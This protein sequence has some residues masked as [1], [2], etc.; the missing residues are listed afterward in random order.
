MSKW[1]CLDCGVH[2]GKIREHFDLLD[3]VWYAIHD[4]REGMICIADVEL[5]LGRQLTPADFKD[6]FLNDPKR[7][8]MSLRLL[9]RV[10]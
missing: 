1:L 2:T 5:R 7:N 3:E 6:T 8:Q 9:S 10:R 4:S